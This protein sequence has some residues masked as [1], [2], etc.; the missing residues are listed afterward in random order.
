MRLSQYDQSPN[1]GNPRRSD[2]QNRE[3]SEGAPNPRQQAISEGNPCRSDLRIANLDLQ[4]PREAT[5]V[6]AISRSRIDPEPLATSVGAISRS[7]FP[8]GA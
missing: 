4:N 1:R 7:R 8:I 3:S 2:L 6:G 5:P